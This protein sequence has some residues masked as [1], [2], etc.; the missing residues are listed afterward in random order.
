MKSI[1]EFILFMPRGVNKRM[2][3]ERWLQTIKIVLQK[4]VPQKFG[5]QKNVPTKS[6]PT[7]ILH[8]YHQ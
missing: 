1:I 2:I 3:Y 4:I 7:K 5:V 6:V 8:N